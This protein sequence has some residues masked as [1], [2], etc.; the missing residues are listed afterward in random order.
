[1]TTFKKASRL[2]EV[3]AAVDLKP[4]ESGD[5]R[6]V[7]ISAGRGTNELAHLRL[8]LAD[9]DARANRFAKIA[10]T[11]HR[12]CGKSTELLCLEHEI[13]GQF[14]RLHLY[15]EDALLGD[16]DYT[17]LFLWLVDSL[18]RQFA[19]AHTPL[20]VKLVE[21]VVSWF[22]HITKEDVSKVQSEI[23]LETEA[24]GG[25]KFK[26]FGL[27]LGLLARLK[28]RILGS[29]EHRRTVRREF[30]R[31]SSELV[32]N[33]NSLLDNAHTVLSEKGKPA[34]L[35]IVIDNLDRVPP[36]VSDE[37]FFKNGD[38]LKSLRAHVIY[39][40]PIA[41]VLSPRSIG[42]VFESSFT[43][44]MVKV[45]DSDGKDFRKGI[46]DLSDLVARR[47]DVKEIF[48][49]NVLRYLVKMSGG[50]VR[51]LMRLIQNA[52]LAARADDKEQI[53]LASAKRAVLKMQ[54]D[55][56]RLLIPGQAY[57]PLLARIHLHKR[58]ALA[59]ADRANVE[60]VKSF[61]EFFSQLLFN[62]SVLEY[63]GGKTW[64]DVHPV[65]REIGAFQE[66][67]D[68]VRTQDPRATTEPG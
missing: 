14:T 19:D 55:F 20:N 8:H 11:G 68:H 29:S 62:G 66:S 13:A 61:R 50:S 12:G 17:D 16:Y 5:P 47:L 2:T 22:A 9:H 56:E 18:V 51:D 32:S 24:E 4:L 63:D 6:Y 58:D 10:F 67:V 59:E 28:S 21:H 54:L 1:M 34:N 15:A 30:Q 45:Q 60:K 52:Q 41:T 64:Y 25:A 23:G 39:T 36:E 44:P 42:T 49:R 26:L 53:D 65:V 57:F 40:V 38:H 43:L 27:S 48:A 31:F 33:V 35:L 3:A 7:D 46:N 37:L